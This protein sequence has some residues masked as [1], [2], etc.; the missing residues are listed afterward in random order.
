[1]YST[2]E[3]F[4]RYVTF[5][6][7][8]A[9][10]A[11]TVPSTAGQFELARQLV[12]ELEE[13]GLKDVRLSNNAYVT[14]T[15]PG[16]SAKKLP[17]IGFIAHLDTATEVSGKDVKPRVIEKYEGGD[18]LLN[19]EQGI[20][21]SPQVFPCL[22]EWI[23]EDLVV[24]DGTTLLGADDKAGI[25]EIMGAVDYLV[26]H[27]EIEHG[28]MKVAFTP[29]EEVG[30]LAKFLDLE[31]FGADFA[32]T[33]DGGPIGEYCYENFNAVS[34]TVKI[35]G[36]AVHPGE[37][38]G[39]MLNA[40]M[41]GHELLALFPPCETPA[42]TEGYE[43]FYHCIDFRGATEEATLKFIIRDHDGA[44]FE[45]RKSFAERAVRWMQDKYGEE[46]FELTIAEQYRNM[47]EKLSGRTDIVEAMVEAMRAAGIEPKNKPMRGGTDG[48]A[49]SWR[50]L[51][52]PNFFS[53]GYNYHGRFEFIPVKAL[54][55]A[56]EVI[57]RIMELYARKSD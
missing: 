32:F 15:L 5:D 44:K 3:R 36:R 46:R 6:T 42:A 28:E 37:A 52:T 49:L 51:V 29:D 41:L 33:V 30:H 53:G 25:A 2:L 54:E 35:K 20:V 11:V 10:D 7:Q 27:P 38:K 9:D 16:N 24:T 17:K 22:S 19:E 31:A 23:G 26:R 50:G 57:V 1:M 56:T 39:L 13:L 21:L 4:L 12:T 43:G 14:A 45:G 48:A 40:V 55:K 34:A 47:A 18:I 8:S